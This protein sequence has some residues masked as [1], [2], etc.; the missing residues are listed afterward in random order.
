M[1]YKSSNGWE[2]REGHGEVVYALCHSAGSL[3]G[4]GFL[5]AGLAHNPLASLPP[6]NV[7]V[8]KKACQPFCLQLRTG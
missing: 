4:V 5:S 6:G 7:A 2:R 3:W 1:I 8:A